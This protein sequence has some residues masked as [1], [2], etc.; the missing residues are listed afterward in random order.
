MADAA[1]LSEAARVLIQTGILGV[2][3][4]GL[5]IWV[6]RKDSE[7]TKREI[8]HGTALEAFRV[9]RELEIK[10]MRDACDAEKAV[11]RAAFNAEQAARIE[12]AKGYAGISLTLQRDVITYVQAAKTQDERVAE[13]LG[14]VAESI[15]DLTTM[16]RGD[17]R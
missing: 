14:V 13:K 10:A 1:T 2:V 7:A 12:D 3:I 15:K 4:L 9:A 8:A 6:V 16:L 11:M 5:V 17:K